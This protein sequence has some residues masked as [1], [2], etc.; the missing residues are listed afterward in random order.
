MS[1][2]EQTPLSCSFWYPCDALLQQSV[3]TL[4]VLA[5][6][7][8]GIN[9][10][11]GLLF[12]WLACSVGNFLSHLQNAK[13]GN[14]KTLSLL[15]CPIINKQLNINAWN[16]NFYTIMC[17][18]KFV[19]SSIVEIDELPWNKLVYLI[20]GEFFLTALIAGTLW[21]THTQRTFFWGR[22]IW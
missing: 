20:S 6:F 22:T 18:E 9:G 19:E 17:L 14:F 1:E 16:L 2:T 21:Y 10:T 4:C 3:S 7:C 8:E 13:Q 11:A 15:C 5:T 12:L